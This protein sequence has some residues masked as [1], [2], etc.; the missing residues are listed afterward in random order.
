M[1]FID[2]FYLS[3]LTDR[4][5]VRNINFNPKNVDSETYKDIGVLLLD[6]NDDR[7]ITGKY[8]VNTVKTTDQNGQS[9]KTERYY[10]MLGYLNGKVVLSPYVQSQL[11]YARISSINI[12]DRGGYRQLRLSQDKP[13]L[14]TNLDLQERIKP[15]FEEIM[16]NLEFEQLE[17]E[18]VNT[19][20]ETKQEVKS[21]VSKINIYAGTNE[22]VQL[23]NFA[24][25]PFII[26]G[27]EF[28]SVEQY[29]QYQKWNYLKDNIS[30]E[31]FK[32][33]QKIADDIINTSNGAK[34]KSLGRMFKGLDSKNWNE[35]ASKE[36]KIALKASFEQNDKAKEILLSTGNSELTHTQDS[37]K[38][39]TE[40]PK[41]LMEVREELGGQKFIS[42]K[43]Q[44]LSLFPEL[45]QE[46]FNNLTEKEK[47]T[48]KWQNENC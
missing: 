48:I 15:R 40:F 2:Q 45:S 21:E 26:G 47:A 1:N 34:L 32:Y 35:N 41:L 7:Y 14:A 10:K 13:I 43:P 27:D 9:T 30:E 17:V 23:S 3:N 24:I 44:Q 25:R 31:D 38:W 8:F 18:Q 46:E 37:G 22:N 39:K 16:S 12:N 29:F 20:I 42:N 33:S 11:G 28:Q 4:Q 6:V 5:V 36:M 19:E